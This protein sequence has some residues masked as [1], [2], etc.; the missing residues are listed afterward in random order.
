M[1][2]PE[3]RSF[4]TTS[5]AHYAPPPSAYASAGITGVTT[6]SGADAGGAAA[7]ATPGLAGQEWTRA[8]VVVPL[9]ASVAQV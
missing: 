3:T 6:G 7:G 1:Q 8:R 2:V 4:E 9:D 5:G